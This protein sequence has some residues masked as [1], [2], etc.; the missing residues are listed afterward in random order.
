MATIERSGFRKFCINFLPRYTLPSRR[1]LN[2][3]LC[4]VYEIEKAK[5]IAILDTT[6]WVS[7][8]ADI[9]SSH[10][11]SYLGVTVHFVHPLTLA[12]V[13]SV[14]TCRRFKGSHTGQAIGEMLSSIFSEFNIT[15][16]IQNVVTDNAA[17]F[18][19]AFTLFAINE[20]DEGTTID[21]DEEQ[22][23]LISE[24]V[25]NALQN[26]NENDDD[27]P[28]ILPPHKSCGNHS[29]NLVASTDVTAARTDKTYQ[30]SYDRSMSKVQALSNATSRSSKMNDM[31]EEITGKTFLKPIC[32]RW[33]SDFYSVERVVD[34]GHE[35]VVECQKAL[36]QNPMTQAD[37]NF[38]ISYLAVMKPV[39]RAMKLLESETDCYLGTMIPTILS[40]E[41]KLQRNNDLS[42]KPLVTALLAGLKK[43]FGAILNDNDYKIATV[44]HPKFKLNFFPN[45]QRAELRQLL[46][47]Y[48]LKVQTEVTEVSTISPSPDASNATAA[49][50]AN[51][52]ENDDFYCILTQETELDE[53]S[54]AIQDQVTGFLSSRSDT[55]A[56]LLAYPA[57]AEAFKKSNSTLPSSATVERL[58]SAAAQILTNRRCTLSDDN[59]DKLVFTRAQLKL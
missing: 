2:R 35:K 43:R 34:I 46:L 48:V 21:D 39:E 20:S 5:L 51:E 16:K 38:L 55:M 11:R 24:N 28:I 3:R 23:L 49:A 54:N 40:L 13:S 53:A 19:K 50:N 37:M 36:G 56:G 32:T 15:S 25:S 14:L 52:T 57:V 10:K 22:S 8:T 27:D 4:D 41:K 42:M 17:N 7:A 33:C 30:K 18:T 58:F 59:F 1:T 6:K 29:L 26:V 47:A 12:M 31:V 44:L 9:W 45:E